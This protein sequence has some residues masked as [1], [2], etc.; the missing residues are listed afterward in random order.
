MEY[1]PL[2]RKIRCNCMLRRGYL[3]VS[4]KKITYT[5]LLLLL[6]DNTLGIK[7]LS[8]NFINRWAFQ[9][10]CDFFFD[11]TMGGYATSPGGSTFSPDEVRNGSVIFVRR[12]CLDTFFKDMHP[13]IK[14]RYILVTHVDDESVPGVSSSCPQGYLHYLKDPRLLAWFGINSNIT[15][16]PKFIPIPIGILQ[17]KL[18]YNDTIHLNKLFIHLREH[19][20]KDKL[21][22]MNFSV[23][24]QSA[25]RQFVR[26][27]FLDKPFCYHT[28]PTKDFR[29]Y[30]TEMAHFK[31]V[32]S[33]AGYG[34]DCYRTWEA[35]LVGCIPIVKSSPLNILYK[36]LPVLIINKWEEITEDFLNSKYREMRSKTYRLD[37]LYMEYWLTRINTWKRLA[38]VLK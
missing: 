38:K 36:D 35:L 27:L 16:H 12:L 5:I 28:E 1:I 33:P 32:L 31:F 14:K 13:R 21:L 30:V 22:Y 6:L 20:P 29:S 2:G 23:W 8:S 3:M 9:N 34:L 17:C 15:A 4:F 18:L 25:E 11:T 10:H 37:K 26:N 7:A 19:T 24:P